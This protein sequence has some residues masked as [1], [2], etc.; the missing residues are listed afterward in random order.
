MCLRLFTAASFFFK[1]FAG[2]FEADR[3][4]K[5]VHEAPIGMLISPAI[6]VLVVV[7]VGLFPNLLSQSIIEPSMA[8]ILNGLPMDNEAFSVNIEHWHGWFSLELWMTIG[9]VAFGSLIYAG[10]GRW[11]Q[12]PIYNKD[13]DPFTP[14]YDATMTGTIKGSQLIT[15]V[16]MTGRLRDYF[17]FMSVFFLIVS[18]WTM[19]RYDAFAID[20]QNISEITIYEG[21]LVGLILLSILAL[22]FMRQ[23][24][25][26]V[27]MLGFVGF[28]IALLFVNF[29]APDLAL[30]QL[31]IETV[32]IILFMLVFY[33]LPELRKEKMKITFKWTNALISF[34]VG[35]MVTVIAFSAFAFG[36]DN[37]FS[38]ISEYYIENSADLAG[39]YNMV[40]VVL[41][42][43]R[44]LDTV[45]EVLVLGISALAVVALVR[46]KMKEGDDI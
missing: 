31:L 37:D 14:V 2:R 27:V 15:N 35:L 41:V 18:V 20:T 28:L 40:N 17:A 9:V 46:L 6:L 21:L 33:H 23:R 26:A 36:Q 39:G 38:P 43:F 16:Q 1:T 3:F 13:V 30:T 32:L 42:D 22:P 11:S 12:W 10:M 34:G 44:S 19:V 8:S 7:T 24:I 29:R 25:A 4:P 45:L 5:K